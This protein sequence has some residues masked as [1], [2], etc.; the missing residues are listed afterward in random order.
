MK[1]IVLCSEADTSVVFQPHSDAM[2]RRYETFLKELINPHCSPSCRV[3]CSYFIKTFL[4]WKYEETDPC[5]WCKE[6]LRECVML[7]LS[8]FHKGIRIRSVRHYFIPSF[9]LLSVKMT[10]EAQKELLRISDIIHV[11]QSDISIIK[12][13]M[14]L[15]KVW[16]D[17]LNRD[18]DT[19][20]A[21]GT[22][23]RV[24]LRNDEC[25]VRAI[26]NLQ[27]QVL[28]MI[29]LICVDLLTWTSKIEKVP[30]GIRG[31][32]SSKDMA[33]SRNLVSTI[34]VSFHTI[35]KYTFLLTTHV[36]YLL[37]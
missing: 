20:N 7:L 1:N 37:L 36:Y 31:E 21:F 28:K 3:L 24:L 18:A 16:V 5:Y 17:C 33:S 9:N 10:D 27:D 23:K 13:C 19:T 25:I 15:N 2:L 26:N 14:T 12:E 4:F 29:N 8:D 32:K 34:Q 6:N 11:R 30:R 22:T 35:S